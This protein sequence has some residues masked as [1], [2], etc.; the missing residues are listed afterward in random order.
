MSSPPRPQSEVPY[1]RSW[2]SLNQ[3]LT[4]LKL[5][6]V[7]RYLL[8]DCTNLTSLSINGLKITQVRCLLNVHKLKY[9]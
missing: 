8:T 2:A 6:S 1:I 9:L 3:N 7:K 4:A 5:N